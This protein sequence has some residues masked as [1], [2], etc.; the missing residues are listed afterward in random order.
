MDRNYI[1]MGKRVIVRLNSLSREI[2]VR[3][4]G[5]PI[6][7]DKPG[8][9]ALQFFYP[10]SSDASSRLRHWRL[11]RGE[12]MDV[13]LLEGEW[14][15]V[16]PDPALQG[17]LAFGVDP[18]QL[19]VFL[20]GIVENPEVVL[21]VEDYWGK[22]WAVPDVEI[23]MLKMGIARCL[24]DIELNVDPAAEHLRT[25]EIKAGERLSPEDLNALD[26]GE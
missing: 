13:L 20:S 16:Q 2:A 15:A 4:D 14:V 10:K 5:D 3:A 17:S 24:T 25:H 19:G 1:I 8:N 12:R 26:F 23:K 18:K 21:V 11:V 9:L 7:D 6:G 22:R